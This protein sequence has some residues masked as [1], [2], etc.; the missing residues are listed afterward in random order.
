[1]I[2]VYTSEKHGDDDLGIG[3]KDK[4]FKTLYR[5]V[6][7]MHSRCIDSYEV[8]VD[9]Q[10][11][12][13]E[14][15]LSG[16]QLAPKTQVKKAKKTCVRDSY[17]H[18][19]AQNKE[20]EEEE[21]RLKNFEEAKKIIIV[22]DSSLPTA[23]KVRIVDCVK[24]RGNRL[25]ISGWVHRLRRQGKS[26]MFITLRDGTGYLQCVLSDKLCHTYDALT[27]QTEATVT[28]YGTLTEV[29][30]GKSAP[31][32][33]ELVC[34][35]WKLIANAPPGGIDHVLNEV[36]DVS[37]QLDQRHLMLRGEK[38]SKIMKF[39]SILM[40]SFRDH[41]FSKGFFEV[42]PPTMVQTQVEGG[43]TLFKFNYYGEEV[44]QFQLLI[45]ILNLI[46]FAVIVG[47]SDSIISAVS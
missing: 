16:Y 10:E 33:H 6:K 44:L 31:D 12:Q 15:N 8:Y 32:G 17:K 43:S 45:S 34:D 29:P 9:A 42:T 20:A 22:L 19:Q 37:T 2:A 38:L 4:P 41:F 5:A 40:Q 35:Y 25:V 7:E 3:D 11:E 18:T 36:S 28:L 23:K 13:N 14:N 46:S 26:L 27:L 21:R 30:E 39:R 47:F 24:N 1:M